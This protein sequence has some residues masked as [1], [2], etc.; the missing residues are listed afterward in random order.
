MSIAR[1][2]LLE[3]RLIA[4]FAKRAQYIDA[5]GRETLT[6][7][8]PFDDS[9]IATNIQVA[10]WDDIDD[11]VA[12]ATTACRKGPWSKFTGA[13]RKACM[14]KFAE[15]VERNAERFAHLESLPTGRPI[16]PIL[17]FDLTHMVQ[18]YRCAYIEIV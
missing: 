10:G 6:L 11:A 1:R 18:V 2:F 12:A 5:R 9:V 4:Y 14:L 17:Q 13:Q 15:L 3:E 7:I 16:T 8:N